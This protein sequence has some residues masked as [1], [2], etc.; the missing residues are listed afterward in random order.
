MQNRKLPFVASKKE[1][2][3]LVLEFSKE[4]R[5]L[6]DKNFLYDQKNVVKFLAFSFFNFIFAPLYR[7]FFNQL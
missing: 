5:G 4:S 7:K 3:C 2:V 1:V 6:K